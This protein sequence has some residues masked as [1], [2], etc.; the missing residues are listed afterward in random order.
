MLTLIISLWNLF[1]N[2]NSDKKIK[3][4]G[5][6]FLGGGGGEEVCGS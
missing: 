3:G 1:E 6:F 2:L 4:L 5:N